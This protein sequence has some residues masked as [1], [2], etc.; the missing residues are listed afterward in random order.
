MRHTQILPIGLAMSTIFPSG[1]ALAD[2]PE[3]ACAPNLDEYFRKSLVATELMQAADEQDLHAMDDIREFIKT[4]LYGSVET[5]EVKG[6]LMKALEYFKEKEIEKVWKLVASLE[7]KLKRLKG[8]G[9]LGEPGAGN[10]I[11][12]T[13]TGM[14]VG[15]LGVLAEQDI[16]LA[17]LTHQANVQYEDGLKML[18]AANALEQE[19]AAA[20]DRAVAQSPLCRPLFEQLVTST[21]SVAD[22]G[23][24]L[25]ESRVNNGYKDPS[26]EMLDAGAAFQRGADI[27]SG[28]APQAAADPQTEDSA[29]METID[30]ITKTIE[31]ANNWAV[32]KFVKAMDAIFH[33]KRELDAADTDLNTLIND[34]KGQIN[35]VR[36]QI[37]KLHEKCKDHCPPI[38]NSNCPA[39]NPLCHGLGQCR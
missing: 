12:A 13:I 15:G 27:L 8:G 14:E 30:R 39:N 20:F 18:A 17:G 25:I 35:A 22:R 38:D 3:C 1:P 37:A 33:W 2:D 23:H 6:P 24:D 21:K 29:I 5:T 9:F 4:F 28:S 31:W 16:E 19:A 36:E 11:G 10:M 34:N 7:E 32:R 26:G